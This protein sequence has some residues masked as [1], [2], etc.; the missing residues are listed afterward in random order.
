[1]WKAPTGT[2]APRS[3]R[4][5]PAS[6]AGA[7][8]IEIGHPNDTDTGGGAW[9]GHLVALIDE[10]IA[11]DLALGQANVPATGLALTSAFVAVP[12]EWIAGTQQVEGEPGDA[13]VRYT[14]RPDVAS[15][16][17]HPHW[18]RPLPPALRVRLVRRLRLLT[19]IERLRVAVRL[20][21]IDME[22]QLGAPSGG[23]GPPLDSETEQALAEAASIGAV[24]DVLRDNGY[25]YPAAVSVLIAALVVDAGP[26]DD[27]SSSY[28]WSTWP[29]LAQPI[30]ADLAMTS[31]THVPMLDGRREWPRSGL[32][33]AE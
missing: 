30:P 15:Y 9:P 3:R 17:G 32:S 27:L 7:L 31:P 18:T 33:Q 2:R 29:M 8:R 21:L 26:D 10:R 28:E 5:S 6:A 20:A 22:A 19:G 25:D 11:L 12:P 1:M 14:A 13:V 4:R 24:L 16:T 23:V